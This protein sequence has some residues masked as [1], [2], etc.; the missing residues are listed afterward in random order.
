MTSYP[1]LV[2]HMM[3]RAMTSSESYAGHWSFHDVLEMLLSIVALPV[4]QTL[5]KVNK[6]GT[7]MYM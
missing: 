3:E 6:A 1:L 5:K 7:Y 4:R 2:S